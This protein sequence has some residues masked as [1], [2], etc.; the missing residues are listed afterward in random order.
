MER[1]LYEILV[2]ECWNHG[3]KIPVDYHQEWDA[4]VRAISGGLTVLRPFKGQWEFN[5]N[6]FTEHVIPCRVL[7]TRAE[8]DKIVEITM[9]H[10]PDQH[11]IMAYRLSTE[12]ILRYRDAT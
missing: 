7:A 3:T 2:P 5:N 9:E 12:V 6:L 11:C 10:Y 1:H 8:M 4:L